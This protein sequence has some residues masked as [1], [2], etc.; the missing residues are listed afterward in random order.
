MHVKQ[1]DYVPALDVGSRDATIYKKSAVFYNNGGELIEVKGK[2]DILAAL[3]DK[4]TEVED[5]IKTNRL[6]TRSDFD[7]ARIFD[8]YNSLFPQ[9]GQ[10]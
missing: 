2:K 7:I 10:E 8:Y 3:D 4:R 1:P 6:G 9:P 5:Y